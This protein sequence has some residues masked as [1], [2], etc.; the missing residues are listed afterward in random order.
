MELKHLEQFIIEAGHVAFSTSDGRR[1]RMRQ[2]TPDEAA[3]GDSAYRVMHRRVM[4]DKRLADLAGGE[5]ALKR[6][7]HIRASAAE[8]V[9]LL[10]LLLERPVR[11][12]GSGVG[13][14]EENWRPAFDVF[15]PASMAEFEELD[16]AI[17]SEMTA[18]YFGPIQTA[19]SEAKKKS[20]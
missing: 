1:W 8:A 7:A 5:T 18:I 16:G 14:Q 10:P 19:I 4:E 17:V 2:P 3:S 11:G 12:Q 9:Y 20:R 15:D 6:E 13:G